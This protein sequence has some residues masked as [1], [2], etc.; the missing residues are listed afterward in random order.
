MKKL[1][2]LSIVL[3]LVAGGCG[4]NKDYV[5]QQI[6]ASEARTSAN[7]NALEEANAA[8][9]ARLRSLAT[10]LEKKTDMA[11]NEAKGFENY[12][13]IW[14]GEINFDYDSYEI[15]DVA[16]QILSEAG[17]KMTSYP[18]SLVEIAGHTDG[19]G[20][21]KYNIDLGEKRANSAKQ[22]LAERFGISLYRMFTVSYGENKPVAG[23]DEKY[24]NSRNRRVTLTIWGQL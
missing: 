19:S 11:I 10:E 22:Y 15:D 14:S 21:A 18:S 13:I 9:I 20:S 4:V 2:L 12:Q 3:L 7:L 16:A 23:P 24:A 8:E 5:G 17:D 1:L 6:A